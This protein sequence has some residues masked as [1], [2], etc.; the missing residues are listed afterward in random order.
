MS[1]VMDCINTLLSFVPDVVKSGMT[2]A[3][4]YSTPFGNPLKGAVDAI[5]ESWDNF[6]NKIPLVKASIP[7]LWFICQVLYSIHF[8][9]SLYQTDIKCNLLLYMTGQ[10]QN[11]KRQKEPKRKQ[12]LYDNQ[13]LKF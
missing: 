6:M 10:L 13:G 12:A 9:S 2:S 1:W 11:C 3:Y 7:Y 5:K 8:Y 4:S